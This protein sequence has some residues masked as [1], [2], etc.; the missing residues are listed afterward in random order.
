MK[1][2]IPTFLLILGI[3]LLFV[4]KL[5]NLYINNNSK[6]VL[7]DSYNKIKKVELSKDHNNDLENIE[8]LNIDDANILLTLKSMFSDKKINYN[9]MIGIIYIPDTNTKLPIFSRA[10]NEN[11]MLGSAIVS[12]NQ[13]MGELNYP[14]IG[15]YS[16]NKSVLFGGLMD[17]KINSDIFISDSKK[18]YKYKTTKTLVVEDTQTDMIDINKYEK[19][20]ISLMTCYYSSKTGKRFFAIGELEEVIDIDQEKYNSIFN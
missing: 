4:P 7:D 12:P 2:F 5:N 11:L 6:K 3:F 17:I 18:L 16:K 19:P 8:E 20:T 14:I 9:N 13:K 15:H 1:K 10:T